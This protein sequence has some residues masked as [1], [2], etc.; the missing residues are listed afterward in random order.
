M[1]ALTAAQPDLTAAQ[2]AAGAPQFVPG[3]GSA[4]AASQIAQRPPE[5]SA[6]LKLKGKGGDVDAHAFLGNRP[7]RP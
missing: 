3:P 7:Q 1:D 2:S 5:T 4:G 6:I